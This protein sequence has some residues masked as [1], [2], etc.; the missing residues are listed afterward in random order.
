M[1][2]LLKKNQISSYLSSTSSEEGYSIKNKNFIVST[3]FYSKSM[4]GLSNLNF[5]FK[6][7]CMNFRN[8]GFDSQH[9]DPTLS[10]ISN[11]MDEVD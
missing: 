4:M 10:G 9:H 1:H 7:K 5:C 8:F 2:I 6:G 11:E 3:I